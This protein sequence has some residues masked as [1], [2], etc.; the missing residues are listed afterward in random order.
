M[1]FFVN[2]V[3]LLTHTVIWNCGRKLF[4]T[5]SFT[6]FGYAEKL[7]SFWEKCAICVERSDFDINSY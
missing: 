3:L 7:Q 2:G 1:G 5:I 6:L 4:D